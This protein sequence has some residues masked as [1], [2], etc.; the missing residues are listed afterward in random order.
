LVIDA[1][2]APASL[3][4]TVVLQLRLR[5]R[6]GGCPVA[7]ATLDRHSRARFALRLGHRYPARVV[8]TLR[9]CATQLALSR[10]LRVGP[11]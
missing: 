8:P 9:D 2:V 10:T 11:R 7:H 1:A 3:G 5:E 6:C 4:A